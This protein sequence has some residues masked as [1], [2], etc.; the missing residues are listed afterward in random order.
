M[1][2]PLQFL[3]RTH[4]LTRTHIHF[5][6]QFAQRQAILHRADGD[7]EVAADTLLL[8]NLVTPF[9]VVTC[10]NSLMR[11]ILTNDMATTALDTQI[12]I[13]LRLHGV[14]E[15]QMLPICEGRNGL[16]HKI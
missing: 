16:P 1:P 12:L 6:L 13:D 5:I 11:R 8:V 7:T 2:G 15:I 10:V 4:H 3:C 9:T 14:V